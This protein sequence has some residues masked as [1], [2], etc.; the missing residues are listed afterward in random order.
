MRVELKILEKLGMFL[1]VD[2]Q[3][4]SLYFLSHY[5]LSEAIHSSDV[6]SQDSHELIPRA[7]Y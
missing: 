2:I 6:V 1:V 3:S 4:L 5:G 7:L